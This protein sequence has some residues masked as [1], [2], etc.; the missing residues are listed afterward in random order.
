MKQAPRR[1]VGLACLLAAL[2]VNSA[3]AP[4]DLRGK[5]IAIADGDTLR[6]L[7]TDKQP[8]I[9]RLNGIDAPESGQAFGQASKGHLSDLVFGK[10]VQVFG[11]KLDRYGRYVGTVLVN[12]TD[13]NLEQVRAGMAWF[14]REYAGD[15]PADRR[16]AY[17]QAESDAR[18]AKRGLWRDLNP[19]PPWAFRASPGVNA[20]PASTAAATGPIIGNR[21]SKIYHWPSCPDYS[22]IA[23]R[24]RIYFDTTAAAERAGFRAAR[25][26]R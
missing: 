4:F 26:C 22:K 14:Y 19:T 10:D 5:V 9:I 3:A 21:N 1:L 18:A 7:P 20:T 15:V 16:P 11:S 24:N 17:E 25:N 13:A 6:I 8:R 2:V 23:E 12:G